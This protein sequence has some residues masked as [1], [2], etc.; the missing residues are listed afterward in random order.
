MGA[1]WFTVLD[2]QMGPETDDFCII[3]QTWWSVYVCV[4]KQIV[5]MECHIYSA[6]GIKR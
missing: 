5:S 3:L 2:I 4:H 6:S 1:N